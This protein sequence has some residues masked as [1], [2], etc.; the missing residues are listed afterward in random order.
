MP[1]SYSEIEQRILEL[2]ATAPMRQTDIVDAFP[3]E[4]YIDVGHAVRSL[5]AQGLVTREKC[6]HTKMVKLK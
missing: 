3:M 5:D 6:G 2:L 4:L 1:K